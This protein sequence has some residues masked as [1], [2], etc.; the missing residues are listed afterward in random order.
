MFEEQGLLLEA[1][2]RMTGELERGELRPLPVSEFPL[3]DAGAAHRA[4]QS[5][6][7]IGKLA[8]IP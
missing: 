7:T 5:G 6:A 2:T 4:L 3:A 1:M 8:L